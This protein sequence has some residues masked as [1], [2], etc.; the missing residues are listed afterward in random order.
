MSVKKR[1]DL[2]TV[3]NHNRRLFYQ[4]NLLSVK[5]S[6]HFDFAFAFLSDIKTNFLD[7][8]IRFVFSSFYD[9]CP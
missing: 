4:K 5:D 7:V 3:L 1:N 2:L 9:K 8:Y 6:A